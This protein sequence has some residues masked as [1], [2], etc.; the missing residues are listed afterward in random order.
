MVFTD[1][2]S[3][4]RSVLFIPVRVGINLNK[5]ARIKKQPLIIVAL[6]IILI[7]VLFHATLASTLHRTLA[8]SVRL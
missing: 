8:I 3:C 1:H 7:S 2:F 6:Q 5:E 4:M